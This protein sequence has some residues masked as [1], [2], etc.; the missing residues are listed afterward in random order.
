M[1]TGD[2]QVIEHAGHDNTGTGICEAPSPVRMSLYI[3][4]FNNN[5]KTPNPTTLLLVFRGPCHE[6]R[7]VYLINQRLICRELQV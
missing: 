7:L 5:K 6:G 4:S 3:M 1:L 2:N